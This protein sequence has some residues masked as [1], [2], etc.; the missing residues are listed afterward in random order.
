MLKSFGSRK[1]LIKNFDKKEQ[2]KDNSYR[3]WHLQND[4]TMYNTCLCLIVMLHELF[5]KSHLKP[6]LRPQVMCHSKI[7]PQIY[8]TTVVFARNY[9]FYWF[10]ESLIQYI[11]SCIPSVLSSGTHTCTCTLIFKIYCRS[12]VCWIPANEGWGELSLHFG[13]ATVVVFYCILVL[14]VGNTIN[15]SLP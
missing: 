11:R 9:Q 7:T 12:T 14:N 8:T 6:F 5:P 10:H 3:V 15:L 2:E 1:S 4:I 13:T